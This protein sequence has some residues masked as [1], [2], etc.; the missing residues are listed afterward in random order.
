LVQAKR[1]EEKL[2]ERSEFFFFSG[3]KYNFS[4]IHAALTFWFFCV[5][6]KEQRY[7]PRINTKN[8]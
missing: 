2:S 6:A 3:M 7:L 5:K 8:K 1:K 4:K